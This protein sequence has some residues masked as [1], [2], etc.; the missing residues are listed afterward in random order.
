MIDALCINVGA[1]WR[2]IDSFRADIGANRRKI[3]APNIKFHARNFDVGANGRKIEAK[4]C[5]L[6]VY[7]RIIDLSRSL[8]PRPGIAHFQRI[9]KPNDLPSS[10]LGLA[11]P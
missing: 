4:N 1:I 5:N 6:G 7:W 3:G 2:E 10:G 8:L 9:P 11:Q